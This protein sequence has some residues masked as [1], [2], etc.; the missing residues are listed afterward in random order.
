LIVDAAWGAYGRAAVPADTDPEAYGARGTTATCTAQGFFNQIALTIWMYY[1][2]LSVYSY[3]AVTN[4]FN[5]RNYK[6]VEVWIHVAV[7]VYPLVTALYVL[8]IEGFN[9]GGNLGCYVSSIPLGCTNDPNIEC[10]RGPDNIRLVAMIVSGIPVFF[11]LLFPTIMMVALYRHQ[12]YQAI[13]KKTT[14]DTFLV[15]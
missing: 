13:I 12:R 2:A 7:H 14:L 4:Q 9:F 15:R 5:T 6:H 1:S 3:V 11:F 8:S 10:E